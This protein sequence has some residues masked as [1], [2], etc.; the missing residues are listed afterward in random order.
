MNGAIVAS[1]EERCRDPVSYTHLDVY[2][3]QV[4]QSPYAGVVMRDAVDLEQSAHEYGAKRPI[5]DNNYCRIESCSCI[6][7][8]APAR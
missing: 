6:E 8:G 3:R 1:G 4:P 2:K 7:I 5:A